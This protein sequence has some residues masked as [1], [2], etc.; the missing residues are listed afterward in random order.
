MLKE[1]NLLHQRIKQ[2]ENI[3]KELNGCLEWH[4]DEVKR[5][6]KQLEMLI[7]RKLIEN[8]VK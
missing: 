5:L 6:E 1:I 2:L 3:N 7:P 8:V 4:I